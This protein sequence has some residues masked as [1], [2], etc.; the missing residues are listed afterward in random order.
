ML[1]DLD[2]SERCGYT[3]YSSFTN[4]PVLSILKSAGG[5]GGDFGGIEIDW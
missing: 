1:L 4:N 2:K 5:R 3:I